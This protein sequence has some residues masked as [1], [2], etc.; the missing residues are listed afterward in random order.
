MI[1]DKVR[2]RLKECED[3]AY[4]NEWKVGREDNQGFRNLQ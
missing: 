3:A 2:A 1:D 4:L